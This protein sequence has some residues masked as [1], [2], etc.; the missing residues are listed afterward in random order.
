MAIS[1]RPPPSSERCLRIAAALSD[2]YTVTRVELSS[3][4]E[5]M[6]HEIVLTHGLSVQVPTDDN[7]RPVLVAKKKGGAI[8][9][10]SS[11]VSEHALRTL[12]NVALA[13]REAEG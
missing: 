8:T 13:E 1:T 7:E 3:D 6:D 5:F 2:V 4:A 12:I 10:R 11:R 9:F